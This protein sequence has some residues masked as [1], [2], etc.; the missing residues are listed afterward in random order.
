VSQTEDQTAGV[1]TQPAWVAQL[2][3]AISVSILPSL[4]AVPATAQITATSWY[5]FVQSNTVSWSGLLPKKGLPNKMIY[6]QKEGLQFCPIFLV[7]PV[8]YD[9]YAVW[10]GLCLTPGPHLPHSPFYSLNVP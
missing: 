9:E 3:G 4:C 8:A 2:P 1:S 10:P 5:L 7:S 6:R